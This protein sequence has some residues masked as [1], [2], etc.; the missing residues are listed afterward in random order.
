MNAGAAGNPAVVCKIVKETD[1]LKACQDR[2]DM[3]TTV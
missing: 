2:A 3:L 1:K